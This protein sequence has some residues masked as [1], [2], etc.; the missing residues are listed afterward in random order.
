MQ[1]KKQHTAA[2]PAPPLL[3]VYHTVSLQRT[4]ASAFRVPSSGQPQQ[5]LSS[6]ASLGVSPETS[7]AGPL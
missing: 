3:P 1:T 4:T 2:Q 6:A 7:A 5:C